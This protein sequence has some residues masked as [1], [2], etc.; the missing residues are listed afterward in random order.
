MGRIVTMVVGGVLV[1]FGL[2][3]ILQGLDV[4]GGSGMSGTRS[5]R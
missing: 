5:G 1:L 2:V 3:W 4:I